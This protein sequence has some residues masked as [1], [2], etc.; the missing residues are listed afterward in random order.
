MTGGWGTPAWGTGALRPGVTFI[1][2]K[3]QENARDLLEAARDLGVDPVEL[4][5]VVNGFIVPDEVWE[6]AR[7]I[8]AA[9]EGE[10]F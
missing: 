1:A 7:S 8:R 5:A 2:G 4:R 6:Q 10:E 3:T 9:R